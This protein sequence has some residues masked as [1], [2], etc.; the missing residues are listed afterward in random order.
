MSYSGFF[1]N[2]QGAVRYASAGEINPI[3]TMEWNQIVDNGVHLY[4]NFSTSDAAVAL[5]VQNMET[6]LF[7]VPSYS[8]F[9]T[10]SVLINF[11]C[12]II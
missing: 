7:R 8:Q 11:I 9:A 2:R 10:Q 3:L 5:D 4:G 12:F 1:H 6:L